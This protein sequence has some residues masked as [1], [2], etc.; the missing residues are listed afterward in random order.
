[1]VETKTYQCYF[2]DAT[3]PIKSK[4]CPECGEEFA[5]K[6]KNQ[7]KNIHLTIIIGI[8]VLIVLMQLSPA[9]G[10][11]TYEYK[12]A[13][14]DDISFDKDMEVLGDAGWELVFARRA[15]SSDDDAIYEVIFK[16]AK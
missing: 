4:I 15:T 12:I 2:C 9:L 14:V 13:G 7:P 16:R 6:K 1:M 10:R 5:I 8:L 11:P 3:I